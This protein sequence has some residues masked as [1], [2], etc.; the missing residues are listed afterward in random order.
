MH[1]TI[2][3]PL[4][5]EVSPSTVSNSD[6]GVGATSSGIDATHQMNNTATTP[7]HDEVAVTTDSNNHATIAELL[8]GEAIESHVEDNNGVVDTE[9]EVSRTILSTYN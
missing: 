7:I 6:D 9:A 4:S 5:L 3:G 8:N 2:A 1:V